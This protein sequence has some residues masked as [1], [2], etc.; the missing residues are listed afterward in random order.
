[1]ALYKNIFYN[2]LVEDI[3]SSVLNS[4]PEGTGYGGEGHDDSRLPFAITPTKKGKKSKKK[5]KKQVAI[6]PFT[7]SN[8]SGMTGPSKRS[9]VSFG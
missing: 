8:I 5:K 7:R 3:S 1:V 4:N 2:I 9:G 6:L